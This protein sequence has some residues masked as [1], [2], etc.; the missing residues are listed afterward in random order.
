MEKQKLPNATTVLI[1]GILSIPACC[2]YGIGL[3]LGIAA[4][5]VAKQDL[6]SYRLD[7]DNYEGFGNLKTGRILAIIGIVLNALLIIFMI[8]IIMVFGMAALEDPALM[9][10]KIRQMSEQ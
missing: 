8:A 7:P 5:L 2:F 9:Q 3:A 6:R 4:L 10:E 1:L